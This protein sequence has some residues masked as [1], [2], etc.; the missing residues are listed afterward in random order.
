MA[1][2]A[3][4]DIQTVRSSADKVKM[5]LS[6]FLVLAGCVAFYFLRGHGV[7]AQWGVVVLALAL[8][9]GLTLSSDWGKTFIA[10][11]Q[12]A[13]KEARKVVWPQPKTAWQLTGVVFAFV[14]VMSLF[15][16]L[17]DFTLSAV[18]FQWILGWSK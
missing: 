9:L 17:V 16:M 15:L 5:A 1:S 14:V 8:A 10:F 3:T 4:S 6:A 11:C 18:I 7:W 13:W 12:D 2:T